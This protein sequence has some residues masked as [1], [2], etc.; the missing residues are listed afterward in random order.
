[1]TARE[2]FYLSP[3]IDFVNPRLSG[4]SEK[5]KI[6]RRGTPESAENSSGMTSEIE[7]VAIT[8]YK[9]LVDINLKIYENSVLVY[10]ANCA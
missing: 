1:M 5:S 2:E 10:M 9:S 6:S 8:N 3:R 4:Y 7:N